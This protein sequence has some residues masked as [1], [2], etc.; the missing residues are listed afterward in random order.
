[1]STPDPIRAEHGH[2]LFDDVQGL[3]IGAVLSSLGVAMFAVCGLMTGGTAGIAFLLHYY[4]GFGI[5]LMFF[6]TNLPFFVLAV[7]RMG[8][9]FTIKSFISVSLL[10]VLVDLMPRFVVFTSIAPLYAALAGG[11]LLGMGVLAF[12]R[13]GS[14][15]GGINMLAVYLQQKYGLRA[16]KIQML[17]DTVITA[18]AFVVL[19]PP[20]V[21]YSVLGAVVLGTVL[22]INHKPGRY[23]GV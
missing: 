7:R 16:G 10:S 3:L 20:Q 11:L 12:V 17:V 15:L 6:L 14:S 13:H 1:M 18:T 23:M 2:T 5:G 8:W 21:L 22:A 9:P 4:T 19:Q